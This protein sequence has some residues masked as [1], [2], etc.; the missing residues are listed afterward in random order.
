MNE[1]KARIAWKSKLT[2][3]SGHGDFLPEPDAKRLCARANHDFPDLE[4]WLEYQTDNP[5][6]PSSPEV[7]T[8]K[9]YKYITI[10]QNPDPLQTQR[11]P[12]FWIRNN[13]S[14]AILGRIDRY[15][16]W[17]MY[18]F[19]PES[20]KC[21]FSASCLRDILDFMQNHIPKS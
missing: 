21:V 7:P 4:H 6:S 18:V 10:E 16:R 14:G 8:M 11:H 2:G 3:H 1:R 13:K 19:A 9:R 17:N 5:E 15:D 12:F 20:N